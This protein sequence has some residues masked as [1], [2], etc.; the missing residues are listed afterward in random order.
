MRV[1]ERGFVA[2]PL[3]EVGEGAEDG[4]DAR[5]QQRHPLPHLEKIAVVGDEAARGAEVDDAAGR[6]GAVPEGVDVRHH[7]VLEARLVAGD[8]VEV[9]VVEV[10]PH[11]GER[12]VGNGHAKRL[13]RLREGEPE[14]APEAVTGL[15]APEREHRRG[16]VAFGERRAVLGVRHEMRKSVE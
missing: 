3:G 11:L 14:T 5:P 15:W 6:G 2:P 8:G 13:L 4:D 1:A 10:R 9:D 16:G 12:L 7:I